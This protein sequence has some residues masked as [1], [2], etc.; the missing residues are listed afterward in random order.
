M[1]GGGRI[2]SLVGFRVLSRISILSSFLP[3]GLV[4][5]SI[6]V[7]IGYC[8]SLMPL[9]G[10]KDVRL[11]V[12]VVESKLGSGTIF[13]SCWEE[14]A[15]EETGCL[16]TNSCMPEKLKCFLGVWDLYFSRFKKIVKKFFRRGFFFFVAS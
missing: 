4:R 12:K 7:G 3:L 9:D 5:G 1:L 8:E 13:I 10:R 6:C 15:A 14:V 2:M 16:S 11:G